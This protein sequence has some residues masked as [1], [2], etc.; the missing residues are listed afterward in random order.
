MTG[1]PSLLP[2]LSCLLST[3]PSSPPSHLPPEHPTSRTPQG[4]GH[5]RDRSRVEFRPGGTRWPVFTVPGVRGRQASGG[6]V[7]QCG[8]LPVRLLRGPE[9][10]ES[11]GLSLLPSVPPIIPASPALPGP[12]KPGH[13]C[14]LR[15]ASTG[16]DAPWPV[17]LPRAGEPRACIAAHPRNRQARGCFSGYHRPGHVLP[18]KLV[19]AFPEAIAESCTASQG[20]AIKES[21]QGRPAAGSRPEGSG[22]HGDARA[23][24]CAP[25]ERVLRRKPELGGRRGSWKRPGGPHP[26]LQ[27]Q[28][29]VSVPLSFLSPLV[30]ASL[31][32]RFVR[33]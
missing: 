17:S 21:A 26:T 4:H 18:I 20:E 12:R 16:A 6:P 31:E 1:C 25:A 29:W 5:P 27:S 2:L 8:R 9:A 11:L 10:E 7:I 24:E 15:L 19:T 23:P 3:S 13:V 28:N 33:I 22:N 32:T 30:C 14:R